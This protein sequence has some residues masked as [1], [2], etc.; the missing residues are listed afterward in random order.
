MI[1]LPVSRELLD[2]T[3]GEKSKYRSGRRDGGGAPA[4]VHERFPEKAN[5]TTGKDLSVKSNIH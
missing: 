3:I 1:V 4:G 5:G 2:V